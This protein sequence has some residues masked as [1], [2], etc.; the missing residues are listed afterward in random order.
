MVRESID[1]AWVILSRLV[2]RE[3]RASVGGRQRSRNRIATFLGTSADGLACAVF[4]RY[5]VFSSEY[6]LYQLV[7]QEIVGLD[8]RA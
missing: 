7:Y 3:E 2:E 1:K 8:V 6:Q 5:I 4:G